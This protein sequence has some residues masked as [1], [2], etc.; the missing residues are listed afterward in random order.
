MDSKIPINPVALSQSY[1]PKCIGRT[2]S[3]NFSIL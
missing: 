2:S 1:I 3:N